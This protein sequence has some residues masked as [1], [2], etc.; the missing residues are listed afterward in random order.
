MNHIYR[1]VWSRLNSSWIAV[2]ESARGQGKKSIRKLLVV[3]TVAG[4]LSLGIAY[5]EPTGGQVTAGAGVISQTINTTTINQTSQNLSLS[6]DK[7]NV[8]P[9]EVVNFVQPNSAA[10]AVNRIFDTNGSQILGQINANGKI[11]LINPNGILF[12]LGAQINVGGLIASTLNMSDASLNSAIRQFSGNGLGSV[13]NQGAINTPEGGYVAFLGNTVSNHGSIT[14]PLGTVAFGAGSAATLTFDNNNL[15]QLQ[16][17]QSTLNNLAENKQLIKADG[18]IVIM[19]AGAKDSLL[20]SV[21]NNTGVIEAQT[22][23]NFGEK[24]RC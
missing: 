4:S 21:V 11:Y 24:L 8:A 13:I 3:A 7:F 10:I 17:D 2:A 23:Q 18:G 6:W 14:A 15:V 5:A 1:L 12:G 16:I 9:H 19:S 20:S 22:L